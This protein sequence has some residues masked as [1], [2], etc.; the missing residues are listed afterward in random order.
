[1]F[2][3]SRNSIILF[4]RMPNGTWIPLLNRFFFPLSSFL[5]ITLPTHS[6]YVTDLYFCVYILT[7]HKFDAQKPSLYRRHN[8]DE[9]NMTVHLLLLSSSQFIVLF[10][11]LYKCFNQHSMESNKLLCKSL[12]CVFINCCID[13]KPQF[14]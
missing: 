12:S 8:V 2:T 1:M 7:E 6:I 13:I 4:T 3:C 5:Y 11:L 10:N 14:I 9:H